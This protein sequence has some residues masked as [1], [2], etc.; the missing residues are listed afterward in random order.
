MSDCLIFNLKNSNIEGDISN[1]CSAIADL[2]GW[3]EDT[4]PN[5]ISPKH[6]FMFLEASNYVQNILDLSSK[7]SYD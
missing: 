6:Q 4:K 1:D 3:V 7:R 2:V 5:T